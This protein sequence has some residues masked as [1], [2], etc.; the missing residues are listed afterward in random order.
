MHPATADGD[1]GGDTAPLPLR[2]RQSSVFRDA[3]GV[4]AVDGATA[5]ESF[6]VGDY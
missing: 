3:A 1:A 4:V 2:H 5:S 6:G